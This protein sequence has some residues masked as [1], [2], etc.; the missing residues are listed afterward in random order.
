MPILKTVYFKGC[1]ILISAL[2]LGRFGTVGAQTSLE[3]T[4][5]MILAKQVEHYMGGRIEAVNPSQSFSCQ[6]RIYA[7]VQATFAKAGKQQVSLLWRAPSGQ[8]VQRFD[9]V[10]QLVQAPH[11]LAFSRW[12]NLKS[13]AN[14]VQGLLDPSLGYEAYIGQWQLILLVGDKAVAQAQ[15]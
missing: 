3:S 1:L 5:S 15:F 8:I 9:E 13:S 12:L 4:Y 6:E 7:V 14:V 2:L 11:S 10:F